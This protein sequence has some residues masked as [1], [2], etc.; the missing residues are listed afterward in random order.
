MDPTATWDQMLDAFGD[1]DWELAL[2]LANVL[3]A[4]FREGGFPSDRFRWIICRRLL[5]GCSR[6]SGSSVNR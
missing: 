3:L 6:H 4:W 2:E 1:E 5:H